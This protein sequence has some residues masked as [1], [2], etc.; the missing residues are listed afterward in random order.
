MKLLF[1]HPFAIYLIAGIACLCIMILVDYILGAEAE[2]LNAWVI[3]N[4][5]AGN[6]SAIG[7]SLAI[8]KLGLWGAGLLMVIING[9]LGILLIQFIRL[10]IQMIHS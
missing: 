9:L 3:I 2:H 8:R 10:F 7:D 1:N 6:A 4:R 5:F